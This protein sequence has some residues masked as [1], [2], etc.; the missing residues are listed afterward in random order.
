MSVNYARIGRWIEARRASDGTLVNGDHLVELA[1]SAQFF[2]IQAAPAASDRT[3]EKDGQKRIVDERRLSATGNA[4]DTHESAKRQAHR[5][6]LQIVAL[7]ADE[8]ELV[9]IALSALSWHLDGRFAVEILCRERM[10]LEH[11]LGSTFKHHLA[12]Q[13]PGFRPHIHHIVGG[14]HHVFVVLHDHHR[15]A[16]V[17]QGLQRINETHVV[18]LMKPDARLVEDVKHI[19]E[20]RTDLRGKTNA[21]ARRPRGS[22]WSARATNIQAQRRAGT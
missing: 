22:W 15:V 3:S 10:A 2:H 18:A 7:R 5:D 8:R 19:D 4:S 11:L 16:D 13:P 17:A 20:L 12:A 14:Q 9:A 6:I 1:Q 21:L